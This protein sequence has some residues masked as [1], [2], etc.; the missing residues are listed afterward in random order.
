M[1]DLIVG[2][3]YMTFIVYFMIIEIQSIYETKWKYLRQFW[4]YIEWGMICCTWASIGIFVWRHYEMKRIG[5][6]FHRSKGYEYV[7][8]QFATHMDDM[9]TFLLGFCCFFGTIKLL[10]FCRYHRH[11]SLLGDTLRYVGKDL[12]FF[13]ASFAIITTAFIALFYLVFTSKI[14]TCSSVLRTAQMIFEMILMKFDASEI[15]AADDV[16]GPICFTLFIFLIVFIGMTMFISIISDGFRSIRERNR[17]DFKTDF[18]IFEFMW[19][20]FLRQLGNLR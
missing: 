17:A 20:R 9:L 5:S 3:I 6:V 13:T 7:N 19:D 14:S 15:R 2:I 1:F 11:L 4:C 12:F 16:L 8:L 10:R 18:E